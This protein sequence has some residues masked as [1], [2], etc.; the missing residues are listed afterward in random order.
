ML[1]VIIPSLSDDET[2]DHLENC[3]LSL[4]LYSPDVKIIV[5]LNGPDPVFPMSRPALTVIKESS[6]PQGQ[7]RAVNWALGYVDTKYVM[8][9][10]D[11]MI[12]SPGWLPPM[13]EAVDKHLCVSPNLVESGCGAEP[14]SRLDCGHEAN[15]FD[16]TKWEQWVPEM[17]ERGVVEHGFNLPFMTQTVIFK[18]IGGY[19]EFYDPYSSNSDPDVM[20][21]MMLAGIQP[22]RVRDSLVYHFSMQSGDPHAEDDPEGKRIKYA[23]WRKNWSYFP[24]KWGFERDGRGNIWYAG[25]KN[26][27]RVPTKKRP[28]VFEGAAGAGKHPGKD[29]LEY[30]P[31]WKGKYGKPFYGLGD[32]YGQ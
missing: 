21:S 10:N 7:C 15:D 19:D 3:I 1:T 11:D 22:H 12:F 13:M 16:W 32:Y 23:D 2:Y 27:T 28:Y 25:G 6:N 30:N 9:S 24:Q 17:V 14:F 29:W 5:A 4:S 18:T 20:H 8:V 26:G 31:K